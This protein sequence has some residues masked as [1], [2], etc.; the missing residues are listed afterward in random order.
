MSCCGLMESIYPL[1]TVQA[2]LQMCLDDQLQ[3]T[4][5]LVVNIR[6]DVFLNGL[7]LHGMPLLSRYDPHPSSFT[8]LRRQLHDPARIR[9]GH[10][11]WAQQ[12]VPHFE[13]KC[14]QKKCDF[15]K[16]YIFGSWTRHVGQFLPRFQF[17][18]LFTNR[19][20]FV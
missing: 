13:R 15:T 10:Q 11:K 14:Y 3:F 16:I 2:C 12:V 4:G 9:T 17:D 18:F 6:N 19:S 8:S 1:P 5:K 7:T 20:V